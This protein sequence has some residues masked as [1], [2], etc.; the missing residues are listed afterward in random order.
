MTAPIDTAKAALDAAMTLIHTRS[1]VTDRWSA[2]KAYKVFD[3]MWKQDYTSNSFST[4][5]TQK[6]ALDVAMKKLKAMP[7]RQVAAAA[8]V[9]YTN[10]N[11]PYLVAFPGNV[12]G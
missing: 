1:N 11:T 5:T 2:I 6:I 12:H 4:F 7:T 10:F 8:Y 3:A 9:A